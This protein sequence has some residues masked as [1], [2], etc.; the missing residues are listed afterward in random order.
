MGF[1]VRFLL[2]LSAELF[3]AD[4]FGLDFALEGMGSFA[5]FTFFAVV[6]L[7]CL[8]LASNF[9]FV[10]SGDDDVR[11]TGD[12]SSAFSLG[13]ALTGRFPGW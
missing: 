8:F 5:G 3:F 2:T 11:F 1:A 6:A 4:A 7:D 12:G 13:K 9:R 10:L